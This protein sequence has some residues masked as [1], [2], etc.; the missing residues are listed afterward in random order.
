MYPAACAGAALETSFRLV[1]LQEPHG[2]NVCQP[3]TTTLA[4]YKQD[5]E[6]EEKETD[7]FSHLEN[8]S[9]RKW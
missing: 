8:V 5:K 1:E 7:A 6:T 9:S 4:P 2:M 3:S